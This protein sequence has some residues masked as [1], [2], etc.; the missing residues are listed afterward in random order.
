MKNI[1][2]YAF[3]ILILLFSPFLLFSQIPQKEEQLKVVYSIEYEKMPF[4]MRMFK[5]HLPTKSISYYSTIG[6]RNE[7]NIDI[8]IMGDHMI[9]STIFVENDSLNLR[10]EKT[11]TIVNDSVVDNLF[12]EKKAR[13]EDSESNIILGEN[14]KTILGY[15]CI[16]FS[17][18]NDSS[19]TNGFLTPDING[20]GKFQDHGLPLELTI[21]SKKQKTIII[22]RAE[23]ISIEPLNQ[24]KFILTEKQ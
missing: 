19:K 21:T 24:K 1:K 17:F 2:Y 8:K 12:L 15:S 4:K 18:E 7:T 20:K 5:K 3:I 16:S 13:P 22:Q 11:L 10:W 6:S 14:K 9:S 23:I